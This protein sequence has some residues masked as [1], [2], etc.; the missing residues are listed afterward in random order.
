MGKGKGYEIW[1]MSSFWKEAGEAKARIN[2]QP[3][4]TRT[5]SV[6]TMC[7]AASLGFPRWAGFNSFE[8][9][10]KKP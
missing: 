4:Q 1:E 7:V 2:N 3:V 8:A 5:N 10:R 6:A 9:V